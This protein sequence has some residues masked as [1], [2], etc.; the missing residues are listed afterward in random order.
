MFRKLFGR[1]S[2]REKAIE[3]DVPMVEYCPSCQAILNMQKGFDP[4][5]PYWIC[6]G[7][8]KMLLAPDFPWDVV[9]QCDKCG[10]LFAGGFAYSEGIT[11]LAKEIPRHG[12][13]PGGQGVFP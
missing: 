13:L 7:C 10:A 8:G 6:T 12:N 1:K 2:Y 3:N 5:Q 11:G 4:D 9:W